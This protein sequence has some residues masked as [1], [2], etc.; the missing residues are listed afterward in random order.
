MQFIGLYLWK[1]HQNKDSNSVETATMNTK[2]KLIYSTLTII[3]ILLL[4]KFLSTIDGQLTPY[5]D[6]TTTILSITA[7]FMMLQRFYQQWFVYIIINI[8]SIFMWVNAGDNTM[9][10]MWSAYLANSIL[11]LYTWKKE[12]NTNA[13]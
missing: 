12:L 8:L 13:Q 6:A 11:G 3:G 1:K 9:I 5:L 7:Q 10:L 4:G 2:S